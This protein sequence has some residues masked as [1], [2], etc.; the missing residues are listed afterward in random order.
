MVLFYV[1]T[2]LRKCHYVLYKVLEGCRFNPLQVDD[3][4]S[5]FGS[6]Q[7]VRSSGQ[8]HRP[9]GLQP[10]NR[11]HTQSDVSLLLLLQQSVRERNQ[12]KITIK[13]KFFFFFFFAG[14]TF[15]LVTNK[16]LNASYYF[17]AFSNTMLSL[18]WCYVFFF[19]LKICGSVV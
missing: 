11:T 8:Q 14:I 2:R 12:N 13:W 7:E 4:C 16:L 9:V 1:F 19:I 5:W 15:C 17:V 10:N 6:L 18:F 3:R